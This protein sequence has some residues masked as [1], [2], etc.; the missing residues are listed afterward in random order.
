M[1]AKIVK[2]NILDF[3][4]I[5][6]NLFFIRF[7]YKKVKTSYNLDK[8]LIKNEIKKLTAQAQVLD[9][10]LYQMIS[11]VKRQMSDESFTEKAYIIQRLKG[12]TSGDEC[13]QAA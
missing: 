13:V 6:L 1:P 4:R 9:L 3:L 5:L 8:Y 2:Y 11:V 7:S 12:R 10:D